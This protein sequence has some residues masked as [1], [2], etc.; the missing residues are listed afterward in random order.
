MITEAL[1]TKLFTSAGAIGTGTFGV[2]EAVKEIT[3]KPDT[4]TVLTGIFDKLAGV[5]SSFGNVIE[6]LMKLI[7]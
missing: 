4:W 2:V 1:V 6:Q 5:L 7:G 3:A